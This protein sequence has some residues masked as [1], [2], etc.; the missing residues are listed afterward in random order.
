VGIHDVELLNGHLK[1]IMFSFNLSPLLLLFQNSLLSA[2]LDF[3]PAFPELLLYG[4][5][6]F[7]QAS[8]PL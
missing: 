3:R 1:L 7:P 2:G 6:F 4:D 5:E 8:I